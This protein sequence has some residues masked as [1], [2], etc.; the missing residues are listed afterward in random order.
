MPAAIKFTSV[1]HHKECTTPF[2]KPDTNKGTWNGKAVK[3][4][5]IVMLL[6]IL[7]KFFGCDEVVW[8]IIISLHFRGEPGSQTF[9][10]FNVKLIV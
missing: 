2:L 6:H 3:L 10:F 4:V 1:D 9:Y 8:D 5:V 7:T